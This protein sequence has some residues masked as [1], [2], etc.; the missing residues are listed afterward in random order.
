MPVGFFSLFDFT[1]IPVG[2]FS[3]VTPAQFSPMIFG[4]FFAVTAGR[5]GNPV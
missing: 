4:A 5:V 1:G 3:S 2:F